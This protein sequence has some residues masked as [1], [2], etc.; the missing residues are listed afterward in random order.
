MYVGLFY[1]MWETTVTNS[2]NQMSLDLIQH[3]KDKPA[4]DLHLLTAS[5]VKIFYCIFLF[6]PKCIEKGERDREIEISIMKIVARKREK[7]R[8]SSFQQETGRRFDICDQIRYV[9]I[10]DEEGG[11]CERGRRTSGETQE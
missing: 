1:E 7:E 5:Q 10:N 6:S 9:H 8:E 4:Y 2:V 3:F 11:H